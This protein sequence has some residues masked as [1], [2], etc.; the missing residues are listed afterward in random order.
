MTKFWSKSDCLAV[1]EVPAEH[2]RCIVS[3]SVQLVTITE[4]CPRK[5]FRRGKDN[6]IIIQQGKIKIQIIFKCALWGAEIMEG[7]EGN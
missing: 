1:H 5:P 4:S 3:G 2:L 6:K 7:M